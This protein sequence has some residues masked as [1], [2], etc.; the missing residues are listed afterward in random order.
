MFSCLPPLILHFPISTMA[1][2]GIH[3]NDPL[4]MTRTWHSSSANATFYRRIYSSIIYTQFCIK[5]PYNWHL[6]DGVFALS[7]KSATHNTQWGVGISAHSTP[8]ATIM[9]MAQECETQDESQ[10]MK[11]DHAAKTTFETTHYSVQT[12]KW[13]PLI[14]TT[15]KVVVQ[16]GVGPKSAVRPRVGH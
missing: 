6:F 10:P 14:L 7:I 3:L 11:L 5:N 8:D 13:Y 9:K 4:S 15:T 12:H 1:M 16:P 2:F